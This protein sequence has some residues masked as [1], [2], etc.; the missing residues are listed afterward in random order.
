M[1]ATGLADKITNIS[2]FHYVGSK[3]DNIG[4]Y[5]AES[6]GTMAGRYNRIKVEMVKGT[7]PSKG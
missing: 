4:R 1:N 2:Q 5:V 6:F 3:G 7:N